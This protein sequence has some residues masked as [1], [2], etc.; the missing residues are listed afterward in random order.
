MAEQRRP[1]LPCSRENQYYIRE[2]KMK[3]IPFN[4]KCRNTAANII[5]CALTALLSCFAAITPYRAVNIAISFAGEVA[6]LAMFTLYFAMAADAF[7]EAYPEQRTKIF[8]TADCASQVLKIVFAVLCS[9]SGDI[10]VHAAA[11]IADTVISRVYTAKL[12]KRKTDHAKQLTVDS[13][14]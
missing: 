10:A 7:S 14:Q 13:T 4:D 5:I 12:L 2:D 1:R 8:C 6:A 11:L 9:L 3:E